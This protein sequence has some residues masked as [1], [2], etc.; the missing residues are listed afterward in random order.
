MPLS[1]RYAAI[2]STARCVAPGG[3]LLIV[4]RGR[5]HDQPVGS[6]PWPLSQQELLRF[7]QTGLE[8][9]QFEDL[10]DSSSASVRRFR[11]E[12]QRNS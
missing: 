10:I 1:M 6:M 2:G 4:T 9:V 11:V 12:Y 3:T 5:N 7:L 8:E